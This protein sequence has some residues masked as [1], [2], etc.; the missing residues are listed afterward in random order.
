MNNKIS[1]VLY[2]LLLKLPIHLTHL[3]IYNNQVEYTKF[4]Y[5]SV[6]SH[7]D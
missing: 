1:Y 3:F 6:G 4:N 5:G 7:C 2:L